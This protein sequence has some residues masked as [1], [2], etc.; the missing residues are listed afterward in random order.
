M[1]WYGP[2]ESVN[3][4]SDV[5]FSSPFTRMDAPGRA[6][7]RSE[8]RHVRGVRRGRVRDIDIAL[9]RDVH[10]HDDQQQKRSAPTAMGMVGVRTGSRGLHAFSRPTAERIASSSVCSAKASVMTLRLTGS[11]P[12]NDRMR[13]RVK[14]RTPRLPP[15]G[16][17]D[18]GNPPPTDDAPR[19]NQPARAGSGGGDTSLAAADFF[20]SPPATAKPAR[21]SV[22]F[23]CQLP[24]RPRKNVARLIGAWRERCGRRPPSGWCWQGGITR[25]FRERGLRCWSCRSIFRTFYSG[26]LACGIR[27]CMISGLP[28]LEAMQCGALVIT[29]RD[30]AILEGQRQMRRCTWTSEDTGCKSG[31]DAGSSRKNPGGPA[32]C[33]RKALARPPPLIRWQKTAHG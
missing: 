32:V 21:K 15:D 12:S 24:H 8:R 1:I 23:V 10:Q 14:R 5:H 7:W 2:G 30:P 6:W 25:S 28:V 27:R 16:T 29:S 11:I 4:Q 22:F 9:A 17:G 26:A 13:N 33:Q 20:Q 19:G 31:G 18:D 3:L